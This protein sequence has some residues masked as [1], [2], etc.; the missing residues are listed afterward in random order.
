MDVRKELVLCKLIV[1]GLNNRKWSKSNKDIK[2]GLK[3][4]F[5]EMIYVCWIKGK[6]L[7][8]LIEFI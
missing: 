2:I 3:F 1:C 7:L 4:V 5:M 6:I 8:D